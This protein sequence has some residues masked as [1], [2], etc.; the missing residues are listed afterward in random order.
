MR[1]ATRRLVGDIHVVH[2]GRQRYDGARARYTVSRRAGFH[3][4]YACPDLDAAYPRQGRGKVVGLDRFGDVIVLSAGDIG[5]PLVLLCIYG[6]SDNRDIPRRSIQLADRGGSDKNI[7]LRHLDHHQDTNVALGTHGLDHLMELAA[8]EPAV[9]RHPQMARNSGG[10]GDRR[11]DGQ[12][13]G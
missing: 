2:E 9:Y 13:D 10:G 4:Q 3:Q 8:H 5:F 7:H 1:V 6:Q 12:T 11:Q